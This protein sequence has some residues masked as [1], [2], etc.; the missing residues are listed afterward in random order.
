[1]IIFLNII[2]LILIF[3]SFLNSQAPHSAFYGTSFYPPINHLPIIYPAQFIDPSFRGG[4]QTSTSYF[5]LDPV[6]SVSIVGTV[7]AP[8][9]SLNQQ[10]ALDINGHCFTQC[11]ETIYAADNVKQLFCQSLATLHP[12][13]YEDLLTTNSRTSQ[14]QFY[15]INC[16]NSGTG[17]LPAFWQQSYP[18]IYDAFSLRQASIT[19]LATDIDTSPTCTTS[20][21]CFQS[22]GLPKMVFDG[23]AQSV[24]RPQQPFYCCRTASSGSD[25]Y[26]VNYDYT[27][28]GTMFDP[29]MPT[30]ITSQ[31]SC[32]RTIAVSQ[33]GHG[34][35]NPIYWDQ[36]ANTQPKLQ[37]QA[38]G[39]Q[40]SSKCVHPYVTA[41][42][43]LQNYDP[44]PTSFGCSP[45]SLVN[46]CTVNTQKFAGDICA[47]SEVLQGLR[48]FK[49]SDVSG[50]PQ[51]VFSTLHAGPL[52][53]D[54]NLDILF[55]ARSWRPCAIGETDCI[56]YCHCWNGCPS[57]SRCSRQ[58]TY[59]ESDV[60]GVTSTCMC[61]PGFFGDICQC[62]EANQLCNHGT[63]V[64]SDPACTF[65]NIV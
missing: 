48:H 25:I 63:R 7:P 46:L 61:D 57:H 43:D 32:T 21:M 13:N 20:E 41:H 2:I 12:Y 27:C 42:R 36:G 14:P 51:G 31:I 62:K 24:E 52:T 35:L 44:Q 54:V 45:N 10:F 34:T 4:I 59:Y 33:V 40:C 11:T 18:P 22:I 26:S 8:C 15:I 49:L 3:L 47:E 9:A 19:I 55:K 53:S 6:A 65:Y 30:Q 17:S 5:F 56:P 37:W 28:V 38:T 58:G 60:L 1:M 39:Y 50:N 64:N 29:L 23:P 16:T